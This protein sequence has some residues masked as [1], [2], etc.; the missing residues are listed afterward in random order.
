MLQNETLLVI[1]KHCVEAADKV[2]DGST[3]FNVMIAHPSS[4]H[5]END[6]FHAKIFLQS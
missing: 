1:F 5:A 3:S 2:N 4:M 6:G